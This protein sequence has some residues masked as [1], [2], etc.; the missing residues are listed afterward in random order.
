MRRVLVPHR[1][2]AAGPALGG[3][4]HLLQGSTMGTTWSVRLVGPRELDAGALRQ[5]V[6]AELD[7]VVAE[8]SSWLDTSDLCRFN[9]APAG[10]WWPL[11]EAC[12]EVLCHGLELAR[13]SRGAFDPT[14]GALVA[15]WGFGAAGRH[16]MPGFV[17]PDAPAV[18]AA[19]ARSG[20]QRLEL[21]KVSRS[22]LQPGGVELDFSGIAK[23][24]GVDRVA[25]HLEAWG[26]GDFLVEVGGELRGAGV[27]PDGQPWWV[28]L[29]CPPQAAG[30]LDDTVIALHG[31]AVATSGDYRQH[32]HWNGRR[33]AH[34]IDPRDGYPVRHG[35][36]SVSVLHREAVWADA[37]AT[38]LTVLG[39][40]EGLALAE[41]QGLAAYF[42]CRD[43][44]GRMSERCSS[45]FDGMRS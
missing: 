18:D 23:G 14:A 22:V 41:D 20:W 39:A 29:E 7:A 32:F 8:M 25:R 34:T 10:R 4:L 3:R 19:R 24:F 28:A 13:L 30:A 42:V 15:L 16:D 2:D 26:L 17:P 35:V 38:A 6:Q 31:L 40:D 1:I 11:P 37:W 43:D 12:F 44:D 27:K 33:H 21:D 5:G 45:A 9:R 36:V